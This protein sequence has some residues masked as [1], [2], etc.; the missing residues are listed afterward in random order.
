MKTIL[1]IWLRA[2]ATTLPAIH[3]ILLLISN[4]RMSRVDVDAL[5][6]LNF[7]EPSC[8]QLRS[9]SQLVPDSAGDVCDC[10]RDLRALRVPKLA[11]LPFPSAVTPGVIAQPPLLQE[12]L[13]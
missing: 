1:R 2:S 9:W 12:P 10:S 11:L 6:Q 3:E 13:S 5:L 7:H 4:E 8:G